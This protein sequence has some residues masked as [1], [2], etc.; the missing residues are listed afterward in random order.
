MKL[1]PLGITKEIIESVGLN[2]THM[3]EDLVFIEHNP[4]LIQFDD[5][6]PSALKIFFNVECESGAAQKIEDALSNAATQNN[7]S[8]VNSGRFEMQQKEGTEEIEIKFLA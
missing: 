6:N 4:F 7:C 8:I 1:R 3:Y 2:V 5:D